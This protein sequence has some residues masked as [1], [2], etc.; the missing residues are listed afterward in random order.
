MTLPLLKHC[1]TYFLKVILMNHINSLFETSIFKKIL[2]K[3][4]LEAFRP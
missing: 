1:Q 2:K 3:C 4:L